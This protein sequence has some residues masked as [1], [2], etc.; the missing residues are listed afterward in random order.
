MKMTEY[1]NQDGKVI[2]NR[3]VRFGMLEG[4]WGELSPLLF[5]FT[6]FDLDPKEHTNFFLATQYLVD[7]WKNPGSSLTKHFSNLV[8]DHYNIC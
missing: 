7:E 4:Y 6:I 8:L 1:K 5:G 2:G 3:A